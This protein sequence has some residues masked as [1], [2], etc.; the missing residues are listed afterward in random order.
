MMLIF[1]AAYGSRGVPHATAVFGSG[2]VGGAIIRALH[3]QD[4]CVSTHFPLHWTDPRARQ[5]DLARIGAALRDLPPATALDIVWAAGR[6]GFA[7]TEDE[8]S[9][10]RAAFTDLMNWAQY[11]SQ[12]PH[13]RLLNLHVVSSAGGLFEGQRFVGADSL[14]R[15]LRPY[16]VLKL[17]QE[18]IARKACEAVPVHIYRPSSVYGLGGANG[19][20]GLVNTLIMN[21]KTHT[22][23]RIF[24]GLDT[25]RDYVLAADIGRFIAAQ[26]GVTHS[27]AKT[28]LLASGKPAALGEVLSII[29]RVVGRPLLIKLDPVPSNANHITFRTSALSDGWAPT[30]IETG[31]RQVMRQLSKIFEAAQHG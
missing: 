19:R 27:H 13:V 26:I 12:S 4:D 31:I 18:D 23:S 25:I 6:T 20:S 3:W 7:C 17:E 1:R 14:P 16:G 5:A 2:L 21:A 10:E 24:G 11:L 29:Y 28:H 15:P 9:D 30:D 22:S 8:V